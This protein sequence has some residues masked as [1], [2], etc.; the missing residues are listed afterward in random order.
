VDSFTK[1]QLRSELELRNQKVPPLKKQQLEKLKSVITNENTLTDI[2]SI[3]DGMRIEVLFTE[4]KKMW[5]RGTYHHRNNKHL[6][7]Y[8]D[9]QE[10]W[11]YKLSDLT[12]RPARSAKFNK[13]GFI[14]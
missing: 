14:N 2:A 6:I 8:D 1:G 13:K 4:P 11:V 7:D 3:Y 10:T 9:G 12:L 5:Y